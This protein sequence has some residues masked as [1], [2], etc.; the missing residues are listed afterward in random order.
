MELI[1]LTEYTSKHFSR[2]HIPQSLIDKLKQD[3]PK[4]IEIN[5]KYT[6]T[7][8]VWQLTAKGWIGHI[9]LTPN[10]QIILHPKVPL[11]NLF[12]M[13][14]YVYNFKTF[15]F[16]LGLT[17]SQSLAGFYSE[18]AFI[19][20]QGI[21]NLYRKG[22]YRNYISKTNQTSYIRGRLNVQK[23][24]QKPWI[25]QPICDYQD[26][27]SDIPDNQIL[28]WTI[29]CITRSGLCSERVLPTVRKAHRTLQGL[30][31]LQPFKAADCL[32]R[33]YHRLNEDYQP[34]HA[35]CHFFLEHTA[36]S[37]KFGDR[38]MLPFL[39]DMAR[40]YEQFVAAWLQRNPP[41][42]FLF[43]SQYLIKIGQNRSFRIDLMLCNRD[44][45]KVKAVLDTKYKIPN[46][47]ADSDIY[48]MISYAKATKCHHAFLVYP[49]DLKER[50]DIKIDDIQV[51]SLTFSL[52]ENLNQAGQAFLY[53]LMELKP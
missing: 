5:L 8:D 41:Q 42:G 2:D 36:P 15:K 37:H 49:T 13:L 38:T 12:G 33:K 23:T 19:L 39:V 24:L 48:Q 45:G 18:L 51:R 22:F 34:L 32:G 46:K 27:S 11:A 7:H 10:W 53:S 25:I 44:T 31:S 30:V 20:A 9:P 52:N 47:A 4:Q 21:L 16:L 28:T 50:L 3:Y 43:Q 40:L 1:E 26:Y 17:N 14:E 29:Y 6:Q 35:I